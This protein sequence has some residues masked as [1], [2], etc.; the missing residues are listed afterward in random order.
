[1]EMVKVEH[2]EDVTLI[3]KDEEFGPFDLESEGKTYQVLPANLFQV[4]MM[5]A[6]DDGRAVVSIISGKLSLSSPGGHDG[7]AFVTTL[8][9]DEARS[10]AQSLNNIANVLERGTH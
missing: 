10:L 5:A 1:M 8:E 6:D 4:G 9:A 2:A 3:E 7:L